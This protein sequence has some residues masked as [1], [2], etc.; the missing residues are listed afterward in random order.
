MSS[1]KC[2]WQQTTT[3]I[4]QLIFHRVHICLCPHIYSLP[5]SLEID[6]GFSL[7]QMTWPWDLCF[8]CMWTN[9][10]ISSKTTSWSL[11]WT[12]VWGRTTF[13]WSLYDAHLIY[14]IAD[15]QV[16]LMRVMKQFSLSTVSSANL[17]LSV[18]VGHCS[19]Y[20]FIRNNVKELHGDRGELT[21][22]DLEYVQRILAK[23]WSS[24]H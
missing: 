1:V 21:A 5:I 22:I 2:L 7:I 8:V 17:Y 24:I 15:K 6:L 4:P 12:F 14:S 16:L 19:Y 11:K 23:D 10:L 13:I 3:V 20:I 9:F 18:Y